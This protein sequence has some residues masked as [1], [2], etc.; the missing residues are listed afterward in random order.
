MEKEVVI[1]LPRLHEAQIQIKND[2]T[3]FRVVCCGRRF[4]KTVTNIDEIVENAL[5][6][7]R[8]G[9]FTPTWKMGR[10]VWDVVKEVLADV[11][12]YKNEQDRRFTT[13][14]GGLVEFWSLERSPTVRGS[15]YDLIIID[16]AAY[17]PNGGQIWNAALRPLLTDTR[18]RALFTTTPF[19][20]N[21]FWELHLL[22]LDPD[23]PDWS[24]HQYPTSAN[25]FIH[26]DEIE[27]AR[28]SVPSL[29]F[30]QEYLAEF[31]DDAGQVFRGV[32]EV[33]TADPLFYP[34]DDHIHVMGLD[35]GKSNDFT[36]VVVMDATTKT[37]VWMERFNK[38][39]WEFQ[40]SKVIS[41]CNKYKPEVIL[42]EENS[43][44]GPNIEAL[45]SLGLPVRPFK[46]TYVS[47][48]PLI[49]SLVLAIEQKELTL[50]NDTQMKNELKAYEMQPLSNGGWQYGAPP[51]T[52]DDI[53]IA[54]A[55]A[56]KAM[57]AP[58][59]VITITQ[60]PNFLYQY[61]G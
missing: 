15:S 47:K 3:R 13:K 26:P 45:Q 18:G 43:I 10:E 56:W 14:T 4:G 41:L 23:N 2:K 32:E 55:L 16:E 31:I 35:W 44:G 29:M 51:G 11:I 59:R 9:Y 30:Q 40:R 58:S 20:R 17:V 53:V 24:F 34:I 6:G 61:R 19:G 36:V 46:T 57:N 33:C 42:A 21:W 48:A 7:K 8:V 1:R 12:D 25:P 27:A 38:I 52:H 54:T 60:A 22:G 50:L 28:S 49:E 37:C 39:S 5:E